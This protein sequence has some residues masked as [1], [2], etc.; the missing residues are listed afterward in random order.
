MRKPI[1]VLA[2]MAALSLA[3]A[4]A[5]SQDNVTAEIL[6]LERRALDGWLRGDPGPQ[7]AIVD[8]EVTYIHSAAATTR[9]NGVVPLRKLYAGFSG[10]PLFDSYEI[11]DPHVRTSGQTAVLTYRLARRVAAATDYWNATEVYEKQTSGW[12]LIHSHWSEVKER[13]P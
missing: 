4:W 7:L 9:I 6:G 10:T 13:Q 12:R 5:A 11:M 1:L 2:A 8:P 3:T